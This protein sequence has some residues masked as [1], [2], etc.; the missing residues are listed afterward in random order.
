MDVLMSL[1]GAG[2]AVSFLHA[3]LPNHWLPFVLAG[4][5]Q[6]WTE[7]KTLSVV[8]VAGGGHVLMTTIL[9]VLIVSLGMAVSHYVEEWSAPIAGGI[10]IVFGLYYAV[11]HFRGGGHSHI[12]LLGH[13]DHSDGS[14]DHDHGTPETHSHGLR[15]ADAVPVLSLIAM[16]TFSPCEGFLPIYL[17]AWPHGW[18]AFGVLSVVLA[19]GT[20][21]G[22]FAFTW[23]TMRG[24]ERVSFP[25]LEKYEGLVLASVLILLGVG[26]MLLHDHA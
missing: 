4:R 22:M 15:A 13:H 6:K 20:L 5:A 3:I 26:V 17:T 19:F 21:A 1:A 18:I 8:L 24:L 12:H 25:S 16:L 14:S 9:G 10:L 7:A 23:L 2:L 11:R